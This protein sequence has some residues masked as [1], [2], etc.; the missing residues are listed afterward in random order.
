MANKLLL[1]R[2]SVPG[3]IPT[4]SDLEYGELSINFADGL[5]HYRTSAN[6]I[7]AVNSY[8]NTQ[9]AAYLSDGYTGNISAGN[10]LANSGTA[11]TTTTTGAL[12]VTGGV[13]ISGAVYTG[14]TLISTGNIVAAAT[15]ASINTTTGALVVAGGAGIAGNV[16]AN[17]LYTETGIYWS[18]NNQPVIGGG[19]SFPVLDWGFIYDPVVANGALDLGELA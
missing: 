10:I 17:T 13:G 9:V 18:G 19:G 5:L 8:G 14:S 7:G 11:S 2:S 4:T 3:K 6:T 16:V 1:K 15:T 12:V